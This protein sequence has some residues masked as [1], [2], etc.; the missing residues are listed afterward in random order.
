MLVW[1]YMT[2]HH[3]TTGQKGGRTYK[4]PTS[5]RGA[6]NGPFTQN[7]TRNG[8]FS[9]ISL[10]VLEITSDRDHLLVSCFH[11]TFNFSHKHELIMFLWRNTFHDISF[12]KNIETPKSRVIILQKN[13]QLM[14]TISLQK[15]CLL[16]WLWDYIDHCWVNTPE[17]RVLWPNAGHKKQKKRPKIKNIKYKFTNQTI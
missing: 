13:C 17:T 10:E 11:L 8:G 1:L 12:L 6:K 15:L 14:R 9:R 3:R 16:H 2:T 4:Q 7:F 5:W